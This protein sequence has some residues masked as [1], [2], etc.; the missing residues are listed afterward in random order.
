MTDVKKLCKNLYKDEAGNPLILTKG[1][2]EIFELVLTKNKPRVHCLTYTQYGKS[3]IV[4]LGILTAV[5]TFPEKWA[6]VAPSNKKAKIIMGYVIDHIFDNEYTASKFE[7]AKGETR[8]RIRRERSK[9][10]RWIT[11]RGIYNLIGRQKNKRCAR[12]FDGIWRP[13]YS[14]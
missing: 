1:Q 10:F 8:E 6:I 12:C 5:S 3:L 9:A 4:G 11:R 7:I 13:K 2:A 14:H